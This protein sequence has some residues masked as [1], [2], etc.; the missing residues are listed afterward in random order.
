MCFIGVFTVVTQ[1]IMG[2]RFYKT[3]PMGNPPK[4]VDEA[5]DRLISELPLKDR[6]AIANMNR[7]ELPVL[8]STYV[9]RI[10]EEYGFVTGNEE[11]MESCRIVSGD[12]RF[13]MS[14]G[15]TL[16]IDLMW[17]RLKRTHTIRRAK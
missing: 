12:E 11:L 4:T 15:P 6:V 1:I 5:V 14:K 2:D 16:I 9:T 13:D 3:I 17:A 7:S 8:Y 10:R